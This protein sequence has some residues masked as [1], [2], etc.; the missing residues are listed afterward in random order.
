MPGLGVSAGAGAA[1]AAGLAGFAVLAILSPLAGY[2]LALAA[3]GLP[4]VLSELR[5]VD[6]RF[7]RRLEPG[8]VTMV[9]AML[10]AIVAIRAA[11]VFHL[12]APEIGVP[13]EL[14]GVALLALACAQGAIRRKALALSAGVA[15]GTA[16]LLAPFGTAITLSVLHN[17]TP[18]GFFWQIAPQGQRGRIMVPATAA[19]LGLPLLVATG[20]PRLL[21]QGLGLPGAGADPL[22]AGPLSANLS[23]YVPSALESSRHAVDLFTAS[24]VAQGGHYIAVIAVLPMLLARLDPRAKGLLRWPGRRVF[25]LLCL[26]VAVASLAAFL[27]GF[28]Q[29][30]AIYGL[31]ASF[32][33]WI[34]LPVLIL[35]LTAAQPSSSP[36][37]IEPALAISETSIA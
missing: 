19:L 12:V 20:L 26:A 29:A 16:T 21:L 17:L 18:L 15:L 32:H 30:R 36:K 27:A 24:V 11:T 5:Y 3:F 13:A 9:L 34:E 33:A 35:A 7:G 31:A 6:R 28:A 4:H 8:L 10:A 37:S 2:S 14:A 25:A 1:L 23:V 22:H